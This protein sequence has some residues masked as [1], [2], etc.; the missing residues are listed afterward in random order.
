MKETNIVQQIRMD[1][2][3][4]AV[5]F[6]NNTGKLQDKNGRWVEFG[7]FIGSPDLIGWRKSDGRFVGIEVKMPGKRPT[8]EQINFITAIKYA[9]GCAGIATNVEEARN[10]I[11]G[12]K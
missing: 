7:L 9:G 4:I 8:S 10:I 12:V 6:R 2:A 3:D 11:M 5:L 1:T